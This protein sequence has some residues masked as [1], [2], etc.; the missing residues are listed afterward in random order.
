MCSGYI[1]SISCPVYANVYVWM[2]W[3]HWCMFPCQY[4]ESEKTGCSSFRNQ[5]LLFFVVLLI[6]SDDLVFQTGLSGFSRLSISFFKFY[7]LWSSCHVHQVIHVH[8][9]KI[10][11]LIECIYIGRA[12]LDFLKKCVKWHL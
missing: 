10:V 8:T 12:L 6:K 7:L 1:L 4:V 11:A 9:H 3:N 5:M 2:S